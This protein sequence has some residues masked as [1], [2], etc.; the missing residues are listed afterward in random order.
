[1]P[2]TQST[3]AA[4]IMSIYWPFLV[5]IAGCPNDDLT[6]TRL[7]RACLL[8]RRICRPR[9]PAGGRQRLESPRPPLPAKLLHQRLLAFGKT[10]ELPGVGR[11]FAKP[12]GQRR[13]IVCRV[14]VYHLLKLVE[15]RQVRTENRRS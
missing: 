10:P 2:S 14:S 7:R 3:R 6:V 15:Q 8:N 11:Q 13:D 4:P 9:P 5:D 12:A 1:M